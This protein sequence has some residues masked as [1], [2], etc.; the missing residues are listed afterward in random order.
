M[1]SHEHQKSCEGLL[2]EKECLEAVKSM[3][4]DKTPGT[5]GL[6]AEF[7]KTFWK[8]ISSL[9]VLALNYAF[10]SGCLFITQR[11]GIIKLIPKKDAELYFIKNWRPITILNMEELL[12]LWGEVNFKQKVTTLEQLQE[13]RLWHNSL[14]RIE[15]KPIFFEDWCSKGIT[16]VKHLQI[17]ECN[18]YLF[19]IE[20]Q[21]K[22]DLN[23]PLLSFYGIISAVKGLGNS[24]IKRRMTTIN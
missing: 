9:L 8:D 18:N 12:K 3:V 14:I 13:Q 1:L 19:L 5:D 24:S 23:V 16:K 20:F 7:Y 21:Q 2:S 4:S 22:Y 11:R 10:E 17:P 15:Y 6:P